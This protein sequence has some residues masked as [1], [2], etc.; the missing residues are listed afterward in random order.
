M[1]SIPWEGDA[2]GSTIEEGDAVGA[3]VGAV[4]EVPAS[5][6]RDGKASSP[7]PP[8]VDDAS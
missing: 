6:A 7:S 8:L 3:I 4:G 5:P 2:V 1:G